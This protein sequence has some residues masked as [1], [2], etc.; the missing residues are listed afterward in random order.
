VVMEKVSTMVEDYVKVIWKS[1]EWTDDPIS[2]GEIA[3]VLGVTASSV[4]GNLKKLARDGYISYEPYGPIELTDR[5]RAIAVAMV[6]RHRLIETYLVRVLGL[7]W[8]EVHH[9]AEMLEHA[10]SDVVL[11]RMDAALGH[12][13]ADPHGDPIP[14]R[15][16]RVTLPPAVRL[17]DADAGFRGPVVRISD[18]E[19]EILRHLAAR[20]VDV[21]TVIEVVTA[22][23]ATGSMT[24]RVD[25]GEVDLA[26]ASAL[27]LW[28]GI[29][30][31]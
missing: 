27:S 15:D 6:R 24:V 16:G 10:T 29:A 31:A 30:T 5:G 23:G 20:G 8:D 1:R 13:A 7:S 2:T 25:D 28:L 22:L 19:S 14:D 18:H 4:S 12:P 17:S 26:E 9:E 21:G 3:A 11:E